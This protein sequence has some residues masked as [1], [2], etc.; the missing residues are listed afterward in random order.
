MKR[1][2]IV[3]PCYNEEETINHFYDEINQY[4]SKSYQF[5]L[6]FVDD[7]SKDST[8]ETINKL[9]KKDNSV[10]YI[11]FSRNFGK[12]AAILA[13]MNAAI[14]LD[15]DAAILMDVDLQDPPNL[16]PKML[17]YYEEGYK[18]VYAKH[19]S[20]KNEPKLRTFFA[21]RFYSIYSYL[22]NDK[23]I[24][25][26][27]R[28]YSLLDREAI[29]AFVGIKDISRFSKGIFSWIGFE[30]KCIEYDYVPRIKGESKWSFIGLI[31]YAF[32]G[33]KQ[34]SYYYK[35]LPNLFILLTSILILFETG[36]IIINKVYNFDMLIIEML[37]LFVLITG[38]ILITLTYDVRD[39]TLNRPMYIIENSNTEM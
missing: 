8:L 15:S 2:T 18:H 27:A 20:R 32:D 5:N 24:V 19:A 30:K 4:L 25:R 37:I 39:Q 14:D 31:K 6:L 13:G 34:F 12:E 26:G 35:I 11:S 29:I 38:R 23:N 17:E 1:I 9:T 36:N 16:V 22:T 10:K 33:I 28:D 3:V 7:G 21:M